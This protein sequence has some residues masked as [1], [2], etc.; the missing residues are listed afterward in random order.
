MSGKTLMLIPCP[1]CNGEARFE[2]IG[3]PRL[4]CIVACLDCGASLESPDV[5][6]RSGESWN[7]RHRTESE[8][9][10]SVTIND[11]AL[12]DAV[13]SRGNL[14]SGTD[15]TIE[16]MDGHEEGNGYVIYD[17]EY[18]DEGSWVLDHRPLTED[19][20]C[21][22][23]HRCGNDQTIA[24]GANGTDPRGYSDCPNCVAPLKAL[25]EPVAALSQGDVV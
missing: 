23:C 13:R 18:P 21:I 6:E 12:L 11:W 17:T 10:H 7:Q 25:N 20:A 15:V 9:T 4:S 24:N 5:G 1:F 3:T 8:A 2:R 16:W 14:F 19:F 22:V